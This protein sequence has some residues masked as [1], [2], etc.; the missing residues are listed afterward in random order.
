MVKRL[1]IAF[2]LI[3]SLGTAVAACNNP[4]GT[5]S[6]AGSTTTLPSTAPSLESSPAASEA[7][8]SAS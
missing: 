8:P 7:A 3:A 1:L 2:A 6:P 4:S 5:T